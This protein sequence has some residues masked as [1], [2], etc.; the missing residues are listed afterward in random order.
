[1]T[2]NTDAV[3]TKAS[4]LF[5]SSQN[6]FFYT[7]PSGDGSRFFGTE[8]ARDAA[9]KEAIAAWCDEGWSEEVEQIFSGVVTHTVEQCDVQK[10]PQ[11]CGAHPDHDYGDNDCEA[12]IA[13]DEF[14]NHEF[15][16]VCNYKPVALFAS[17]ETEAEPVLVPVDYDRVVS[18]CEAHGICLPVDCVEMVVEI[19]RLAASSTGDQEVGS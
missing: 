19:I 3:P 2:T 11:P 5:P 14:P 16:E 8:S 17:P 12:C 6:R 13:W 10:K 4:S 18:I 9:M 15:D 1:M 7:D